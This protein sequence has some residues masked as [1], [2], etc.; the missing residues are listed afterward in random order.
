MS[1]SDAEVR[2]MC[3]KASRRQ[4]LE[5]L[6]LFYPAPATF[7]QLRLT[8]A[9][10]EEVHMKVDVSYLADKKLVARVNEGPNQAWNKREFRLTAAGLEVV[11]RIVTD[12][13]LEP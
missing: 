2:A 11:D 4:L 3:I 10:V 8:M 7:Q 6:K 9:D 12:P 13:A 5:T 1:L